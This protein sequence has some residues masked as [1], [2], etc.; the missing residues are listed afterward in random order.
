[1][2]DLAE[3]H[4]DGVFYGS[5]PSG[6]GINGSDFVAKLEAIH[7]KVFAPQTVVG[8]AAAANGGAGGRPVAPIHSGIWVPVIP[9]GG[10]PIFSTPTS[11][12]TTSVGAT[13]RKVTAST[14]LKDRHTVKL[15]ATRADR[16]QQALSVTANNHPRGPARRL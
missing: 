1:M 12:R 6:N 4:L 8:T 10:R 14:N 7:N 11:P 5:F 2:Q 3:N 15:I 9:V 13:V 16:G